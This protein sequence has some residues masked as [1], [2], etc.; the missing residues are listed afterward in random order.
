MFC[1]KLKNYQSTKNARDIF[2]TK[3]QSFQHH[4][5]TKQTMPQGKPGTTTDSWQSSEVWLERKPSC[6]IFGKFL[7]SKHQLISLV[8][9]IF[10]KVYRSD[11]KVLQKEDNSHRIA[12]VLWWS[13]ILYT[14]VSLYINK[15]Q[16]PLLQSQFIYCSFCSACVTMN[17][18]F[19]AFWIKLY[20][21]WSVLTQFLLMC[22]CKVQVQLS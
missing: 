8:S 3:R 22:N 10:C 21:L 17:Y 15:L 5:T 13:D 2:V 11:S 18:G 1:Q 4:C 16:G 19:S 14:P 20:F 7:C 6:H 9:C 12:C